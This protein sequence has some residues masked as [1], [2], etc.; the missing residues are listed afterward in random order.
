M[1]PKI[2]SPLIAAIFASTSSIAADGPGPTGW[3][4]SDS[5]VYSHNASGVACPA[6]IGVYM[7]GQVEGPASPNLLGTCNYSDSEGRRGIID[8][9]RYLRGVG[10]TPFAIEN[11]RM[12][13][14]GG[15]IQGASAGAKLG[16]YYRGGVGQMIDGEPARI[17]VLTTVR[18]GLLVDC[19]EW[20]KTS[21]PSLLRAGVAPFSHH[22]SELF[23][24][25][26]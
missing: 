23:G 13:I 20:Q 9:R 4:K 6:R 22:C 2:C 3:T 11:D 8:V 24:P 14:D 17:L 21:A 7:L 26:R 1:K 15:Q 18:N 5:G 25:L 10:E 12:L 16:A 19:V